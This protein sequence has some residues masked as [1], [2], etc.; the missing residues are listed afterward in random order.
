M[1]CTE[2]TEWIFHGDRTLRGKEAV[3]RWMTETYKRPP[4]L[5]VHRMVAEGDTLVAMGEVTLED[6]GGKATR[7]AYCDV[8]RFEGR[9]MAQLQAVVVPL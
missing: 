2:D 3:R 1:H 4:Q 7:R 5:Q 6:E 9:R 8:W